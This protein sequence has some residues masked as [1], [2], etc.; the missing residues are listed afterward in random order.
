MNNPQSLD[1]Y[2]TKRKQS[3]EIA[4]HTQEFLARGGLVQEL[5][6][7][8]NQNEGSINAK[9]WDYSRTTAIIMGADTNK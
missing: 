7:H 1:T 4:K 6:H 5:D 8:A 9:S 3:R 2:E